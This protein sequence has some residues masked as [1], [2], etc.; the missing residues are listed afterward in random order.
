MKKEDI[1]KACKFG[2]DLIPF[3]EGELADIRQIEQPVIRIL[4]FKSIDKLRFWDNIRP[5]YFIY[6]SEA[7][8][9]GSTRT[10][11]ALHKKL[12]K[13]N[14]MGIAW[15]IARKNS[16]PTF[17]ALVASDERFDKA[18]K[19]QTTPPGIFLITLPYLDDIRFDPAV[20]STVAPVE[21]IN[22]MASIIDNTT[23][24]A[25]DPCKYMDPSLQW[26]WRVLQAQALKEEEDAIV[27]RDT[28]KPSYKRMA[29]RLNSNNLAGKWKSLLEKANQSQPPTEKSA[30]V[31][32]RKG[33]DSD[34]TNGKEKSKRTRLG[35]TTR[36]TLQD[37]QVA[38]EAGKLD[39]L[40]L[41]HLKQA[42]SS[43][44]TVFTGKPASTKKADILD[45]V[46]EML[47]KL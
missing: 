34:E 3:T 2:E 6:P 27:P 1:R 44:P 35:N 7:N 43:N 22:S 30:E 42:I 5:S 28:T 11:A 12:V 45:Y 10:F 4:G 23:L 21:L 33:S 16:N 13:S 41:P 20:V 17:V 40:T 39:R 9:V 14:R 37:L 18:T 31:V 26:H 47:N 25:Y 8:V 29:E 32:K 36:L 38:L 19:L 15:F 24:S 46:T